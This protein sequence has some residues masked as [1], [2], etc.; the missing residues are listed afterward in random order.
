M[1]V[2]S[3]SL[4]IYSIDCILI[5]IILQA[6]GNLFIDLKSLIYGPLQLQRGLGCYNYMY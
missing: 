1:I 4:Q 2:M 3:F 5:I 6:F